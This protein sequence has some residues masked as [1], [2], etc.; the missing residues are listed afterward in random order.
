MLAPNLPL[1]K[2]THFLCYLCPS[3]QNW[4]A[5]KQANRIDFLP[6][7]IAGGINYHSILSS[8]KNKTPEIR[9]IN[10]SLTPLTL[11]F[12]W[13]WRKF[14]ISVMKVTSCLYVA[15]CQIKEGLVWPI[16]NANWL[17]S[18]FKTGKENS[19]PAFWV[20][21]MQFG[22]ILATN[23]RKHMWY[24]GRVAKKL[25]RLYKI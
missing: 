22:P 20:Q 9:N 4:R 23:R 14:R 15:G 19:H 18:Y 5:S 1:F 21:M 13:N 2:L 10:L 17:S 11:F 16:Y 7:E 6:N 8:K 12:P 3:N 25:N 24:R